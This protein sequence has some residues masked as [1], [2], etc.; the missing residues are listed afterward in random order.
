MPLFNYKAVTTGG[1]VIEGQREGVDQAAVVQWLQH[2]GHIPLRAE[3][4]ETARRSLL[5]MLRRRGTRRIGRAELTAITEE[6]AVLLKAGVPLE[7]ALQIARDASD[8]DASVRL[9]GNV[10]E[11]VRGGKSFS[12]ALETEH[13]NFSA[14]FVNIVR[15]AEAAGALDEGLAQ[16][17]EYLQ[18]EKAL[19]E[20]VVSATLYPLILF[21]V[22]VVSVGLIL[23]YVIPKISELFV[24]YEDVL[25]LSTTL[26]IATA[27]FVTD[28]WWVFLLLVLTG[29]A[30][31]RQQLAR[32]AGRLRWDRGVLRVPY[33]GELVVKIEVAR[34]SR[35]LATL[36][37]NGVPLINAIPLASGSLSNRSMAGAMTDAMDELK[38]GGTLSA[39]IAGIPHFPALAL[40]LIKVGEETGNLEAMLAKMANVYEAETSKAVKRLLAVLEPVLI[41]GLGVIIGSVIMSIMVA[42][43]SVNDLPL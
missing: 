34:L 39:M 18:R 2:T 1:E 32:P 4:S 37:G 42:I 17:G 25:P 13:A 14:L 23:T 16:L 38:D 43:I 11:Q 30:I 28:Y 33:L 22:A 12:A 21:G 20:E 10:L 26:V 9:L 8:S 27:A 15:T 41:V 7:Q 5:P 6:L 24:G 3:P 29:L 31:L 40:Q 35:S 36:L 19:R